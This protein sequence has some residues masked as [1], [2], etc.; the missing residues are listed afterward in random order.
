L[1]T[2]ADTRRG[3]EE[4]IGRAV[5]VYILYLQETFKTNPSGRMRW[6]QDYSTSEILIQEYTDM[7]A[8]DMG[9]RPALLILGGPARMGPTFTDRVVHVD[10]KKGFLI[11][12]DIIMTTVQIYCLSREGAEARSLAYHVMEI[13]CDAAQDLQRIGGFQKVASSVSLSQEASAGSLIKGDDSW[14][15]V[16]VGSPLAVPYIRQQ[17]LMPDNPQVKV[18]RQVFAD[19]QQRI[20]DEPDNRSTEVEKLQRLKLKIT[21]G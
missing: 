17:N 6:S 19:V 13:I 16:T 9:K 15:M 10:G 3:I 2:K 11:E 12:V 1:T 21:G 8:E 20:G 14:K 7:D 18:R 4:A 5:K